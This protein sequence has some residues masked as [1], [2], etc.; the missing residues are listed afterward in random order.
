MGTFWNHKA[1]VPSPTEADVN[2]EISGSPAAPAELKVKMAPVRQ[3]RSLVMW[4]GGLDSTYTLVRLL[5]ETDD[6]VIAHHVRYL[7]ARPSSGGADSQSAY[8]AGAVAELIPELRSRYRP[9]QYSESRVDLS[10]LSRAGSNTG[11]ALF[12]AGQVAINNGLT[13]FDRILL[14]VN[15][16]RDREWR[17]H[18]YAC[19]FRRAIGMRLLRG[20]WES[21]EVPFLYLWQPRPTR[22]EELAYLPEE[23]A[24]LTACCRQPK[25]VDRG[26]SG[27]QAEGCG[28]C[29][30]CLS[31]PITASCP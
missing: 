18:T 8:Q 19:A 13:P 14:G 17:P 10:M 1:A 21:E 22:A 16:D 15:A 30:D 4:N 11:V 9:F 20:V 5:R 7:R 31:R 29:E 6:E 26:L 27:L 2:G 24:A 28:Q 25:T 12:V 23:V 3:I